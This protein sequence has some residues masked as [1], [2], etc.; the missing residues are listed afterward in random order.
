MTKILVIADDFTGALDTGV[1]FHAKGTRIHILSQDT[2]FSMKQVEDDVQV[3]IID[4]ETRHLD[5]QKAYQTVHQ[6]VSEAV[7]AKIPCIYKKTD[8]GLRGNIGAELAALLDACGGE[9]IHFIPSFP[10]L[11][12]VTRKGIHYIDGVPVAESV[13]GQDPFEPVCCS[14]V[15]D[16]I[17]KQSNV[18]TWT[19]GEEVPPE[20]PKGIGIY[21]SS[22]DMQL[23]KIAKTLQQQGELKF[24]AGCAGFASVLPD[25]LGLERNG[26]QLPPVPQ[27]LLV[28]CGSIN[29]ITLRQLCAAQQAGA[30]RIQLTPEQK[31]EEGWLD[32]TEGRRKLEEWAAQA[33]NASLMIIEGNRTKEGNATKQYA[34]KKKMTL[35]QVR[36][37]ISRA[38]GGILE[39]LLSLGVKS[40][41]LVTGGDTLLA[42]MER[43]GQNRLIPLGELAPGVVLSQIAYHKEKYAII[44]KS[45][46]FGDEH[47]LLELREKLMAQKIE[48]EEVC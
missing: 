28:I 40:T 3:L 15:V 13:F 2:A 26:E 18:S 48:E 10:Q 8:S 11:G 16:I 41:V 35:E 27:K 21:D 20:L 37:Q 38:M 42:F 14:N 33:K 5:P 44:S 31:L 25:I 29:P 30:P 39:R 23:H 45:G 43:I 12:R 1:Q 32:S 34:A 22:T 24:L 19:A 47:L 7:W 36:A 6:I 17:K 4:A 46:G 9:R